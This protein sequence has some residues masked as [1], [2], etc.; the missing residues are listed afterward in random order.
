MA[1]VLYVTLGYTVHDRRFL[2]ALVGRGHTL[3]C[4]P[5]SGDAVRPEVP[6][7]PDGV[8]MPEPVVPRGTRCGRRHM[9]RA[10]SVLR[11]AI[12]ET[13]PDLVHAGPVHLGGFAAALAGHR[14]ML[15][16]S[17]GWDV[18]HEARRCPISAAM[19]RFALQR[20]DGAVCDCRT[21]EERLL[22]MA[23]G[24]QGRIARMPWGIDLERFY[25]DAARAR[26]IRR[27]LGWEDRAIFLHTRSL[28]A[29]Y[30]AATLIAAAREVARTEPRARFLLVGDG[31]LQAKAEAEFVR[32]SV[33]DAVRFLGAV[34]PDQLPDYFRA[35][36]VYVSV[37]QTDGTSISLLEAMASG[38]PVIVSDVPGNREWVT[39]GVN[40]WLV[41]PGD[42]RALAAAL[43]EAMA[44][45]AARA[46]MG[47]ANVKVAAERADWSRNVQQ[48]FALYD[49]VLE[50]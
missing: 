9:I 38:L 22:A 30:G 49:Q 28:S 33:S 41:R 13:R 35:A 19:M 37:A 42:S 39:P 14:P 18:L 5:L 6:P 36:D 8:T 7:V 48:L 50:R 31:P 43:R 20:A 16:I 1:R 29:F 46:A 25:P 21:V 2:Q 32:D 3:W 47:R 4:L 10:A 11:R 45:G 12:R 26:E 34:A 23:P 17:W 24:L 27:S 40:G 44:D 15:A